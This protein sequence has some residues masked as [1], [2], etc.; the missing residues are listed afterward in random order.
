MG[1]Q[2]PDQDQTRTLG[3]E[4]TELLDGQGIPRGMNVFHLSWL[5]NVSVAVSLL[6][7]LFLMQIPDMF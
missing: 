7:C 5:L 3:S 6:A 2:F 1:S 4:S